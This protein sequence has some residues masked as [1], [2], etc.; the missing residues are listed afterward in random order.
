MN[1]CQMTLQQQNTFMKNKQRGA[2]SAELIMVVVFV[3]LALIF[4][5]SQSPNVMY[6]INE[7]RFVSQANEIA[8]ETVLWK[9][10]RP[11]FDG[12]TIAKVC[13]DG[14]LNKNICGDSN[15]GKATNP[16][17]GDWTL[18]TNTRSK[19]LFDLTAT[20]P[21]TNDQARI[22]SLANSIAPST[23]G[24]CSEADD[25]TTLTTTANSLKMTY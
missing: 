9:K 24:N 4:M 8:Q 17:G 7:M 16:F 12:V 6:K 10:A 13:Q 14:S 22:T 25:C 23:R 15:D 11:N 1:T 19:G 5:A 20:I 18:A 2:L 21:D 3:V